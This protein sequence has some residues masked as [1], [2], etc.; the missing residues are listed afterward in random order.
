MRVVLYARVSTPG[1]AAAE[2]SIPDQLAQMRSWAERRGAT[3][4]AEFVDPG[5][6]ATDT[7]RPGFQQMID[8]V[9]N[10]EIRIDAIVVHS[11]SRLFRDSIEQGVQRR[12]LA[13]RDTTIVSITQE[14]GQGN[15]G[16]FA[17]QMIALFDE[18]SSRETAKHVTRTMKLNAKE[19]YSN[20]GVPPFG[21]RRVAAGQK[22]DRIKSKYEVDPVEAEIVRTIFKLAVEGDGKSGPLGVK[23][24]ADTLNKT[25]IRT[26]KSNLFTTGG[27]HEILT[28]EAYTGTRRW[29]V[30]SSKT[31]D[32]KYESDVVAYEV[33]T[34]IELDVFDRVQKLLADRDPQK[35]P[36]RF[37]A[38][39]TLLGGIAVCEACG[40]AMTARTGTSRRGVVYQYYACSAAGRKGTTA[41]KGQWVS[42][43]KLDDAVTEGL[44]ERLLQPAHVM[45]L[46]DGA[47]KARDAAREAV[48]SRIAA[49][50]KEVKEAGDKLD[51]LY[52][53]I[54]VGVV[55]VTDPSLKK[56]VDDTVADRDRAQ[57]ALDRILASET[58]VKTIDPMKVQIFSSAMATTLRTGDV[59][60]R[61]AWV[62]ALID[63]IVVGK[64]GI[65]VIGKKDLLARAI[66]ADGDLTRTARPVR[67]SV[68]EWCPGRLHNIRSS[69]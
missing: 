64:T 42:A 53:A 46:L 68:S 16:D 55:S 19:G 15:E 28:R 45:S 66:D 27:V 8:R 54:E 23:R 13:K 58:S 49:L 51:R 14:F 57:A 34:I 37:S 21:Y 11:L 60:A 39:P 6:T 61:K 25:G 10:G 33:P 40:A 5:F 9:M 65:R 62:N 59:G 56:R 63:R 22:G 52:Q 26:R 18:Y 2:L 17:T 32:Y 41:C 4:I 44:V 31:G 50:T 7:N 43:P 3:I 67:S 69:N 36:P 24:I 12:N 38:S 1:Q 47:M 29:N 20:G 48:H 30:R 35:S